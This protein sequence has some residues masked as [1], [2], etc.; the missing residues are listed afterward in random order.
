M[1]YEQRGDK[2]IFYYYNAD[3]QVTGLKYAGT[4]YYFTFNSI[5]DIIGI[6]TEAGVLKAAYE[7]NEWGK[8]VSIKDSSGNSITDGSNIGLI[9]PIRY[10]GY[11]YDT[12]TGLFYV[13]SRYYNPEWGRFINADSTDV[14]TSSTGVPNWD[15]NLFAYYDNDPINRVDKGGAV[16]AGILSLKL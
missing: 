8:L 6:Y 2:D 3:G 9:N 7:Y 14:L 13:G 16:G 1:V 12:E 10:R 11:Y 4:D 5:E 15:K